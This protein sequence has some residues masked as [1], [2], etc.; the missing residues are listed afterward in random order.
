MEFQFKV[1][2][3]SISNTADKIATHFGYRPY[4]VERYISMFGIDETREYLLANE[5]LSPF[6]IRV[7]TLKTEPNSLIASLKSKGYTFSQNN[8][9]P[10]AYSI[11]L[12][13]EMMSLIPDESHNS[14]EHVSSPQ[15]YE[16][17]TKTL[18]QLDWGRPSYLDD[19]YEGNLE[20]KQRKKSFN[21]L[22]G[23][24]TATLGSTHEYLM[25]EYYIQ[26]LASMFPA[27]YLNPQ[28]TDFVIDMCAAP[29]GKTTYLAQ[30]MSNQGNIFALEKDKKRIKPLIYNIRRCGVL[31]TTVLNIDAT[32]THKK[33][34]SPD[35]ILLDAPCTGEGL[36]RDD[37]TRKTSK[38][39]TDITGMMR[40]QFSLLQSAI[41]SIKPGGVIMY[42]TCS[43]A[44][45]ENEFV[46]QKA[47]NSFTDMEILSLNDEWGLPGYINVFNL[48]LSEELLKARRLF[49][50]I[51]NTIGF[52][53][54]LLRKRK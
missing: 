40:K 43:I 41:K 27:F 3:P 20:K 49:P 2:D 53:Y 38:S 28:K 54:C 5:E 14:N 21:H 42:S 1:F 50:H 47:L 52:F 32:S 8:I 45:E 4:M 36:I 6:T 35:K 22:R 17:D 34:F 37:P 7:N 48:D 19:D 30:L 10:N 18:K 23:K 33:S 29:G 44:P 39:I 31:N 24:H 13:E 11:D 26:D 51:H 16:R 25:G 46:I 15:G 12:N 9:I